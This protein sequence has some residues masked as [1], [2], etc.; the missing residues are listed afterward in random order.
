ML[1]ILC[2][3][4]NLM[5]LIWSYIKINNILPILFFPLSCIFVFFRIMDNIKR[6]N[7]DSDL[8]DDW[9]VVDGKDAAS[10]VSESESI[11]V[12]E[13]EYEDDN[14]DVD[15]DVDGT[16]QLNK[17]ELSEVIKSKDSD[18]FVEQSITQ[19]VN[20]NLE[21]RGKMIIIIIIKMRFYAWSVK[22]IIKYFYLLILLVNS[23]HLLV[24]ISTSSSN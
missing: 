12:L 23:V 3:V 18:E 6:N 5:L 21:L 7:S 8:S 14:E 22:F 17:K 16:G 15:D 4:I 24:I 13:G 20:S 2:L 19:E 9:S 11:E 1:F 10:A